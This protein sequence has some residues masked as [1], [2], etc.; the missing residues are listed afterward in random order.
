MCRFAWY[1]DGY[2]GRE[3]TQMAQKLYRILVGILNNDPVGGNMNRLPPEQDDL[4]GALFW[5]DAL[6]GGI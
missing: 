1:A 6:L 2:D 4:L 3:K 5:S